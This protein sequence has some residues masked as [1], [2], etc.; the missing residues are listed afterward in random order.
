MTSALVL[1]LP[2]FSKQSVIQ[3]DA[4]R[5]GMGAVLTQDGHP[6][7]SFSKKFYPK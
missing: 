7:S 1:S 5:T 6:I 4:S 3:T 2:D